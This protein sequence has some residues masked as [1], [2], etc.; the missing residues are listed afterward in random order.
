MGMFGTTLPVFIGLTLI[1]FGRAAWTTGQALATTWR[2]MVQLLPYGLLMAA[3]NRFFDYALFGGA[4]L[5]LAGYV[6]SVVVVVV[7]SAASYRM[8]LARKMVTQYPWLY[9]PAGLLSWRDRT[10]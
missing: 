7:I 6:L 3:G 2:P 4:L 1:L 10:G 9:E 8:T 5:S